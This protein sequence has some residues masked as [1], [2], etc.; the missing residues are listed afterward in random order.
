MMRVHENRIKWFHDILLKKNFIN[1]RNFYQKNFLMRAN[2][3][4]PYK[5]YDRNRYGYK[6]FNKQL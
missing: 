6:S 4:L 3:V 2:V 5:I 1:P